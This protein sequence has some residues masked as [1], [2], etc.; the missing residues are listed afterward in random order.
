MR[1]A[2]R[3]GTSPQEVSRGFIDRA[4]YSVYEDITSSALEELKRIS[5]ASASL[6]PLVPSHPGFENLSEEEQ[7][8]RRHLAA[9][10]VLKPLQITIDTALKGYY[11]P[12]ELYDTCG[13]LFEDAGAFNPLPKPV[14]PA[15]DIPLEELENIPYGELDKMRKTRG[16]D[17][18]NIRFLNKGLPHLPHALRSEFRRFGITL[19][20]IQDELIPEIARR[21]DELGIPRTYG[22][23]EVKKVWVV[24]EQPLEE[25]ILPRTPERKLVPR[26]GRK[27]IN[28]RDRR[29]KGNI[30]SIY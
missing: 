19:R 1:E 9:E 23:K 11:D 20:I 29:K 13:L 25:A 7:N 3:T 16:K 27:R 5:F 18:T 6:I 28:R 8:Y 14:Q 10:G 4:R 12:Q 15:E 21:L 17:S 26:I 24:S 2:Y 30:W 22:K